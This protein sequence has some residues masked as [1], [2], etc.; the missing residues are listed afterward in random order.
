MITIEENIIHSPNTEFLAKCKRCNASDHL[1]ARSFKCLRNK[2]NPNY[3]P[4]HIPLPQLTAS[5]PEAPRNRI[6]SPQQLQDKQ[7]L[8]HLNYQKNI[9]RN[10]N[11]QIDQLV[12]FY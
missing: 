3:I 6:F 11:S 8:N 4:D 2:N 10:I 7:K 9:K 12:N 1:S 5:Q